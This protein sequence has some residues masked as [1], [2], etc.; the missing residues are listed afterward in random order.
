MLHDEQEIT[1]EDGERRAVTEFR[2]GRLRQTRK[3]LRELIKV[4]DMVDVLRRG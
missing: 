3:T 4:H 1:I 2:E